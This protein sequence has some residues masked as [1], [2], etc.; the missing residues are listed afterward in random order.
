MKRINLDDVMNFLDFKLYSSD[1]RK[2]VYYTDK[3]KL[4]I[5]EGVLFSNFDDHNKSGTRAIDLIMYLKDCSQRE[6]QG[7]LNKIY[8]EVNK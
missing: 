1:L 7:I 8:K 3:G 4:F 6:A 5:F 2:N